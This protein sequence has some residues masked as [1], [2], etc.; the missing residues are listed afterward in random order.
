LPSAVESEK[1]R[2]ELIELYNEYQNRDE[3]VKKYFQ[4]YLFK[5]YSE[6]ASSNTKTNDERSKPI[7]KYNTYYILNLIPW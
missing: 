4:E 5:Y 3:L 1:Y 7:H 6:C 2:K